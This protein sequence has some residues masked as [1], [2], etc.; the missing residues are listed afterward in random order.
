V[1]Q[2]FFRG[3]GRFLLYIFTTNMS[4]VIIVSFI[5]FAMVSIENGDEFGRAVA[6]CLWHVLFL[7]EALFIL[8]LFTIGVAHAFHDTFS[9]HDGT[10]TFS[11]ANLVSA[12]FVIIIIASAMTY[13]G[14]DYLT[15]LEGPIRNSFSNSIWTLAYQG[16]DAIMGCFG[17][18]I[19][20]FKLFCANCIGMGI[21]A[22]LVGIPTAVIV[23]VIFGFHRLFT[24]RTDVW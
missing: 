1:I 2:A 21:Y 23:A 6:T 24:R 14:W 22:L 7:V 9:P 19:G 3:L 10:D 20:L 8:V 12:V 11:V 15:R 16:S 5:L 17:M 4:I 13:L 18:A